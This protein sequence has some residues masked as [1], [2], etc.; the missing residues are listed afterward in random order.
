MNRTLR[1][2]RRR[3]KARPKTVKQ[4]S[5][6]MTEDDEEN[7]GTVDAEDCIGPGKPWPEGQITQAGG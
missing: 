5:G 3:G 6:G 2:A 4:Y 7:A 1:A